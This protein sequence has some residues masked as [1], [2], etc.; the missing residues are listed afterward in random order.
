M[1]ND[2]IILS[3]LEMIGFKLS[4]LKSSI[5]LSIEMIGLSIDILKRYGDIDGKK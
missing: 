1:S 5:D 2:D 4:E 3:R